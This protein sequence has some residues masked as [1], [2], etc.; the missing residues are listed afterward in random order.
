MQIVQIIH[1]LNLPQSTAQG[2]DYFPLAIFTKVS[3]L[4]R[5]AFLPQTV[6]PDPCAR[7]SCF[8][9]QR[10]FLFGLF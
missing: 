1:F 4:A 3:S 6:I 10:H 9:Y 7:Y 5:I 2:T 8:H